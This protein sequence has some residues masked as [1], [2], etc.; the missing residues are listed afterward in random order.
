[1]SNDF[2]RPCPYRDP[3]LVV[4]VAYTHFLDGPGVVGLIDLNGVDEHWLVYRYLGIGTLLMTSSNENL[5]RVTGPLCGEFTGHRWIPRTK[6]QWRG[7]LMFSLNCAWVNGWVNNREAGDLRR[8]RAHYDVIVMLYHDLVL[9]WWVIT[10]VT[11][12]YD[13]VLV[14]ISMA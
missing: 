10:N 14:L 12:W 11:L 13:H 4:W 7:A 8:H 5:F 2:W 9:T 3:A 6:G 1:M